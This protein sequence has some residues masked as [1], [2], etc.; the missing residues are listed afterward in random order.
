MTD[1]YDK[2]L[3]EDVAELLLRGESLD[4]VL[5]ASDTPSRARAERLADALGAAR[6]GLPP[7]GDPV[8]G[9][10]GEL[11][12]E[13]AAVAAFR[14]AHA[15]AGAPAPEPAI[16]VSPS[17]GGTAAHRPS[18]IRWGRP[19][20]Y[21]IAAALAACTLG[22]VAVAGG[23]GV[24][25]APF[26]GDGGSKGE[27]RPGTSVSAA[28]TPPDTLMSPSPG[29]P[30]PGHSHGDHTDDPSAEPDAGASDG[31]KKSQAPGGGSPDGDEQGQDNGQPEAGRDLTPQEKRDLYQRV[32]DVCR[33]YQN[34]KPLPADK[35]RRLERAAN[36]AGNV[37]KLCDRALAVERD[38]EGEGRPDGE[39]GQEKHDSDGDGDDA[40]RRPEGEQKPG[41]GNGRGEDAEQ[42]LDETGSSVTSRLGTAPEALQIQPSESS[43]S[44]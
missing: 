44:S 1:E 37:E 31:G 21:G 6:D 14:Q 7:H 38:G 23:A 13:A 36:G 9:A 4:A 22:G 19:M 10:T 35:R 40:D 28:V 8:P 12:G 27:P 2:W 34:G 39:D 32:F 24:L 16:A 33:D 42:S 29:S 3:D 20:R 30:D 17:R 25:P 18:R 41:A 26:G 43:I 5:D 15:S 11:P